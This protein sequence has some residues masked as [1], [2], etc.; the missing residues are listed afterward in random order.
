MLR[1]MFTLAALA[2]LCVAPLHA[3]TWKSQEIKWMITSQGNQASP[4][5]IWQRDTSFAALG[6][7]DDTTGWF[8]LK[9]ADPPFLVN[10]V[11]S[12]TLILGYLVLASDSSVA[13]AQTT[14]NMTV[15]FQLAPLTA[16]STGPANIIN[17]FTSISVMAS[18][19]RATVFP[20]AITQRGAGGNM[21]DMLNAASLGDLNVRAITTTV[22][23]GGMPAAR[24]F[25]V[26]YD[27][28][29]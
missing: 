18:G 1:L 21:S 10:S 15:Q 17:S 22:I 14:T 9:D 2:V 7:A 28:D 19:A 6:S 11:A 4:T 23:G 20:L 3:G 13:V 29:E 26:Y 24:A 25:V 12:D 16:R 8:N 5:A 27:A